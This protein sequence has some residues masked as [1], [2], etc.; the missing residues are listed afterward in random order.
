MQNTQGKEG[1][2]KMFVDCS[3]A[4]S[5]K[6]TLP[7]VCTLG[8]MQREFRWFSQTMFKILIINM[9]KSSGE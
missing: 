8:W 1:I 9:L 5:D 7:I 4:S 2:V 3:C 6:S